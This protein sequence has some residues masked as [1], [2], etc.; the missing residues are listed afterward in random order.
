MKRIS[1]LVAVIVFVA[2]LLA[3][4]SAVVANHTR[5]RADF[6]APETPSVLPP[7]AE[8]AVSSAE[9]TS[10]P[11]TTMVVPTL[12]RAAATAEPLSS[13]SVA[14]IPGDD[15]GGADSDVPTEPPPLAGN[16]L[17][18]PLP[19]YGEGQ[20]LV[21]I[22]AGHGGI[23]EGT[24]P[25]NP[26]GSLHYTEAQVNLEIALRLRDILVANHVR[27]F[28]VRDGDYGIN[29]DWL[30]INGDGVQDIG[31]EAQA[32]IDLINAAGAE[33]MLSIHQ[34][35][36]TY[37]DGTVN[38]EYNGSTT[39]YCDARP[40]SDESYRFAELVHSRVLSGLKAAGYE[41]FDQGILDD[42]NVDESEPRRHFIALGPLSDRIAR[43]SQMPGVI[44]EP[45]FATN[46][47]ES[48]LLSRPEIWD[49][50]AQA[51]ADAIS[52]YFAELDAANGGN[53]QGQ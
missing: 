7:T 41:S 49:T 14:H 27:V 15:S 21:A 39:Y 32:R 47:E 48:V 53:Y 5:G 44:D 37:D 36:R 4:G 40:F 26:D 3:I 20:H 33:L 46:D 28:M 16:G 1:V 8:A 22:D 23:D 43:P 50:L 11:A 45:L 6:S 38:P 12:S 35:A 17:R 13:S 51:Y 18:Q 19:I 42:L 24:Y 29:P 31:D 10:V 30:D 25:Y 2:G 52:T 34:N 9:A